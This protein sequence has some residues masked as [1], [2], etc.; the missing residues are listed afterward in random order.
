MVSLSSRISPRTS[1]VILRERSSRHGGRHLGNVAH[2]I[3][4]VAAHGI[5]R[6]GQIL[7]VPATQDD[8]LAAELAVGADFARHA[9]VTS[10][11]NERS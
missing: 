10:D 9:R 11:A 7:Q 6:V 5:H 8:G 4:E 3:G 1:T 2:L